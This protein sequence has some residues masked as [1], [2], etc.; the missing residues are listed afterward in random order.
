MLK[1]AVIPTIGVLFL[2]GLYLVTPQVAQASTDVEWAHQRPPICHKIFKTRSEARTRCGSLGINRRYD[3]WKFVG[4]GCDCSVY[5]EPTH[6]P[7]Q[8]PG[9][10]W[11]G[12]PWNSFD[13]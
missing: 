8:R 6:I 7:P 10:S 4:Y 9:D 3:G 11:P 5:D 12:S 1:R 13:F 2:I